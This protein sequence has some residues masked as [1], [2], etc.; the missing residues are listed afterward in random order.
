MRLLVAFREWVR[1]DQPGLIEHLGL[2]IGAP[3]ADAQLAPQMVI[4]VDLDV[5]LRRL[6]KL[7]AGRSG[8]YFIHIEAAGF[9]ASHLPQPRPLVGGLSY[10]AD[11]ALFPVLRLEGLHEGF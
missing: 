5:T 6:R 11:D 2:A 3:L 8:S 4:V 10:I 9:F 1:L 7:D